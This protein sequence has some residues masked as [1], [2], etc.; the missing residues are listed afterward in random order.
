MVCRVD[1]HM[2]DASR[3]AARVIAGTSIVDR[4]GISELSPD[5][6]GRA[7]KILHRIG[8]GIGIAAAERLK[9]TARLSS[10]GMCALRRASDVCT[11]QI[12]GEGLFRLRRFQ[13]PDTA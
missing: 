1:A 11:T 9:D 5:D 2:D 7:T 4:E 8:D 6:I 10:I 3:F 12:C 13:L